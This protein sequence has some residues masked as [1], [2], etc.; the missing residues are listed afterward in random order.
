MK[1]LTNFPQKL[2]EERKKR[3]FTQQEVADKI[4]INRGSYSNWENGK[5][6]PTLDNIIKLAN[7]LDVT[8]DYLL[9]RSDNF[10]NTI[11]LSKNNMKSFSK[12]LK[13]LRLEKNQT[14]RQLADELG[15]NRVNVTRWEKGNTE[16]SFSKLIELSKLLNTTPNYLLGVSDA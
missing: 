13:E 11:V 12:R 2:R 16:P 7:I 6:E 15:V 8:V 14:Q 9:G 1:K 5:R 4:G 3:G 10:S